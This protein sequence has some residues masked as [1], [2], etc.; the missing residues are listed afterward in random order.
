MNRSVYVVFSSLALVA[1]A[2]A[3]DSSP[4]SQLTAEIRI[5]SNIGFATDVS[6]DKQA[7]TVIF[8][9][10]YVELN[11]VQAR[12]RGVANQ[13]DI[14]AKVLTL[15]IPYSTENRSVKMTID[16]RGFVDKDASANA[17]LI[18]VVGDV[19]QVVDLSRHDGEVTFKGTAKETFVGKPGVNKVNDFQDRFAVTLQ[20]R[21]DKPVCQIT[22]LLLADRDTDMADAG[23]ALLVVDSLDIEVEHPENAKLQQ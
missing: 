16:V 17:R 13:T 19:T 9:D 1:C 14:Q 22:L 10:A 3:E 11:S 23:G 21:A 6:P 2:C 8:D 20:K 18:V 15:R 5:A 7:A 4:A 12:S